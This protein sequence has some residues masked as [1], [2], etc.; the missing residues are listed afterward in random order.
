[1]YSTHT[2]AG[3]PYMDSWSQNVDIIYD[4][5]YNAHIDFAFT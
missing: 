3:K 1:M 4:S 2:I 5:K